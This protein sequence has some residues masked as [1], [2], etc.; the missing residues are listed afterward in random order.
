MKLNQIRIMTI[1]NLLSMMRLLM[2]PAFVGLYLNGYEGWTA[3]V[4]ISSGLTDVVDGYVARRFNQVS[5]IGK[6]LDPIADKLTQAA[7]LLCL[8]SKYPTM[9]L[10]FALLAIK[11]LFAGI[12]GLVVIRRTGTVLGA[13]WHGKATTLMLYAM[14]I[15][16]V[17]WQDI[18]AWA[19]NCLNAGCIAMMLLS[20]VL[21]GRRNICAIRS[22]EEKAA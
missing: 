5:D 14:M 8:M 1:P 19:S 10:P 15:L 21:Y 13:Q 17:V 3:V 9:L 22:A 20:M 6:A 16:H 12:T 7:M 11:E 18:P 2:I 4:L